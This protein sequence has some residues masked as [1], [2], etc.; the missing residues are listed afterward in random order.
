MMIKPSGAETRI[1]LENKF[2]TIAA[3]V[4]APCV[5]RTSEAM[6]LHMQHTSPCLPRWRI[7]ITNAISAQMND[8]NTNAFLYFIK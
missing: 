1:I 5:G 6:V 8:S 2:N 4:L 3:D 7:S